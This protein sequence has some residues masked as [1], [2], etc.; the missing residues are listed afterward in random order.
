MVEKI[1]KEKKNVTKDLMREFFDS[2]SVGKTGSVIIDK[3]SAIVTELT[4]LL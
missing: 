3:L 4:E 1:I 2:I